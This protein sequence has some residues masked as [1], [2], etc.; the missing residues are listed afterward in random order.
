MILFS[1]IA[2]ASADEVAHRQ[3]ERFLCSA[4]QI[5]EVDECVLAVSASVSTAPSK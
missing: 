5:C 4:S 2:A 1:I 3:E